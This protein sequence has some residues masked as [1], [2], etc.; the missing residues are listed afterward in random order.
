MSDPVTSAEI[1]D[2][3]LSI[4]RLISKANGAP[5]VAM[6]AEHFEEPE[7]PVTGKLLLTEA[8]RVTGPR[9]GDSASENVQAF[10][11]DPNMPWEDPGVLFSEVTDNLTEP[12]SAE[13]AD[14]VP[15]YTELEPAELPTEPVQQVAND[16][17]SHDV[18]LAGA[19][20][21]TDAVDASGDI[22]KA[23]MAAADPVPESRVAADP[24]TEPRSADEQ[25]PQEVS[26]DARTENLGAKLA[27]RADKKWGSDGD[28]E[29]V[30]SGSNVQTLKLDDAGIQP[31]TDDDA[32]MTEDGDSLRELVAEIV[33]EELQGPLGERI[34]RNVRKLVRREFHRMMTAQDF[35]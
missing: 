15:D 2:V 26:I 14:L 4:R 1:E 23:A 22:A 9:D 29:T 31:G 13:P 19:P 20:E 11:F 30:Y 25:R 3:L 21:D 28:S 24:E 7:E 18:E 12:Q 16:A 27:V 35:D 17:E 6:R 32:L 8:L 34:T 5:Q 33:R 10:A